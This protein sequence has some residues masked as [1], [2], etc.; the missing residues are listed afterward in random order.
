VE[1]SVRSFEGPPPSGPRLALNDRDATGEDFSG[2]RLVQLSVFGSRLVRC[3]FAGVRAKSAFLGAGGV[4]S[5]YVECNFDG[6]RFG[7]LGNGGNARFERCSFREVDFKGWTCTT[8]E[9]ID[10]VFTGKLRSTLFHGT[11]FMEANR[12]EVG[13]DRNEFLDNDFAGLSTFGVSFRTGIDLTRQRLPSGPDYAYLPDPE[14][15]LRRARDLVAGWTNPRAKLHG[16]L[17]LKNYEEAVADGQRQ[18]FTNRATVI[19]PRDPDTKRLTEE[20]YELLH[21]G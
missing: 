16:E 14:P 9:M 12:K 19:D 21:S 17:L 1:I 6:A 18:L 15:V 13:R 3:S 7:H 11:V 20:L 2:Q 10:C 4:Q 5:L 8:V